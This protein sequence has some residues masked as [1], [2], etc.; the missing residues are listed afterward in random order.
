MKLK[1]DNLTISILGHGWLGK[2]LTNLWDSEYPHFTY[3]T[4]SRS[5]RENSNPFTLEEKTKILP[6]PIKECDVL[7]IMFPTGRET[8][9]YVNLISTLCELLP[10]N[11][12]II[13]IS[14]TS[15]FEEN[16]GVCTE[17]TLPLVSSQRTKDIHDSEK[18]FLNYFSNGLI[19]RSAGQIGNDRAPAK[20]LAKKQ[21]SQ[22]LPQG[23]IPVNIIHIDD[24][25]RICTLAIKENLKGI[26][27]AVS[28]YHPL[29]SDYYQN[30][31]L[32]L[33]LQ[34]LPFPLG[35][36]SD[37]RIESLVLK[38]FNYKFVNELCAL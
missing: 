29:K 1:E 26:L 20:F 5:G 12:R 32:T 25:T 23:N 35:D 37:K 2:A 15:V 24:L 19:I 28:P 11:K 14:T 16:T 3:Q 13:L 17:E 6:L 38:R 8:K 31:A 18:F 34:V 27:H 30:Q 4:Y 22:E 7:F 21:S 33:G 9:T 36:K 10:K